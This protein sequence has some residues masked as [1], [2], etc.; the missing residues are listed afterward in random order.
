LLAALL[1]EVRAATARAQKSLEQ[2]LLD[3]EQ[4]LA[5]IRTAA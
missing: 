5:E 3:A 1:K 2:G 4:A